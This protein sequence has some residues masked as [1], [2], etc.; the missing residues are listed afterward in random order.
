M[1]YYGKT[2]HNIIFRISKI[3][4]S[5]NNTCFIF[6]LALIGENCLNPH[7]NEC[8]YFAC[9][10][11]F[12]PCHCQCYYRCL[13]NQVRHCRELGYGFRLNNHP[14]YTSGIFHQTHHFIHKLHKNQIQMIAYVFL[15]LLFVIQ[16]P[17]MR[18][19]IKIIFNYK[20]RN[21]IS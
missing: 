9:C 15:R 5:C 14:Y 13:F 17:P 19:V 12:N 18:P 3:F 6:L 16:L 1:K 8:S 21:W 10:S 2:G 4:L 11:N 20:L 7:Y